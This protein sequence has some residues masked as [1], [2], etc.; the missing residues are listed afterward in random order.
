MAGLKRG[1]WRNIQSLASVALAEVGI[2]VVPG[3]FREK[4]SPEWQTVLGLLGTEIG[5][6]FHL[7][8][9][10]RSTSGASP[11]TVPF[12]ASR[13]TRSMMGCWRATRAI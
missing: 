13:P 10:A 11:A 3:R 12:S 9:F 4:P 2:V 6:N 5:G 7:W 1:R 8:R